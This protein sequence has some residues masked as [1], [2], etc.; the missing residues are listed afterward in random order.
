M[1]NKIYELANMAIV[2]IFELVIICAFSLVMFFS[3]KIEYNAKNVFEYPNQVLFLI[4]ILITVIF[5][6]LIV[7]N[8]NKIENLL[9]KANGSVYIVSTIYLIGLVFVGYS[10]YFECAWDP[11]MLHTSANLI[12]SG[13]QR[14]VYDLTDYF[15]TYPNNLMLTAIFAIILKINYKLNI[16]TENQGLMSLIVVECVIYVT[17]AILLYKVVLNM[18][19]S[20]VVSWISY[21]GYFV[22]GTA[23]W[24][25]VPYSDSTA[26]I[27]PVLIIRLYQFVSSKR[28]DKDRSISQKKSYGYLKN[29]VLW[30]CIGVLTAVGYNI[31]PQVVITLIAILIVEVIRICLD[32]DSGKNA[33]KSACLAALCMA[34]FVIANRFCYKASVEYCDI[35]LIEGNNFTPYHYL[36]MG[37]NEET[38]GGYST[39]DVIFS[40]TIAD[41]D[42]RKNADIQEAKYRLSNMVAEGN[43]KNHLIK[44]MLTNFGDG[45]FAWGEE[46]N[47][48][49]NEYGNTRFTPILKSIIYPEGERNR[50]YK[51][52][53]HAIWLV[54]LF[55][56]LGIVGIFIR[57]VSYRIEV[58]VMMLALLGSAMF[59]MLFEARARYLYIYFPMYLIIG[60]LGWKEIVI[61]VKKLKISKI[62][63]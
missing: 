43:L 50:Q 13:N 38:N 48:V 35:E 1:K 4:G 39:E 37:L 11:E 42:E 17:T 49:V 22:W 34:V 28:D 36:M 58:L 47:F 54:I 27:F 53:K 55:A 46:G 5:T 2:V 59:Q 63:K 52:F 29:I 60:I 26:L 20:Y 57:K 41:F 3:N 12:V 8:K 19:K 62:K 21:I 61:Y 6:I 10:I 31:K 51:T 24:A 32:T 23:I 9:G 14:E 7:R 25:F 15:S 45:A 40:A 33:I 44:K 56:S 16:F 30:S 18:T